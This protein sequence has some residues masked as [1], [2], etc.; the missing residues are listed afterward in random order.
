MFLDSEVDG[1]IA[2]QE[3]YS[4]SSALVPGAE[5]SNNCT[6]EA[7][8]SIT[9]SYAAKQ[10]KTNNFVNGL[11]S[12]N[13]K[14]ENVSVTFNLDYLKLLP[15]PKKDFSPSGLYDYNNLKLKMFSKLIT[16]VL[17]RRLSQARNS[18]L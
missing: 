15:L 13:S 11:L 12:Y 10:S 16:E 6:N 2:M 4:E 7:F 3:T 9:S 8:G 14:V 17:L 18:G 1:W 5:E